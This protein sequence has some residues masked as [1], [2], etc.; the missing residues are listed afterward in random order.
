V[1]VEERGAALVQVFPGVRE[2]RLDLDAV[3]RAA[4]VGPEEVERDQVVPLRLR[5]RCGRL[6]EREDR[7]PLE[8]F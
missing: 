2:V 3:D 1:S 4:D 8:R 5:L 6:L 7:S